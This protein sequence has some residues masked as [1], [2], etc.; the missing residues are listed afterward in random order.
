[1]WC[2]RAKTNTLSTVR[3][4][5]STQARRRRYTTICLQS[6]RVAGE[7]QVCRWWASGGR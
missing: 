4:T 3:E 6:R 2:E 5:I 1:I 7:L